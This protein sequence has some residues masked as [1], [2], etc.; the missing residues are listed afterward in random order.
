MTEDNR[1][2]TEF[3]AERIK[4]RRN[5]RRNPVVGYGVEVA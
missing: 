5:G 4:A 2:K 3:M 1:L